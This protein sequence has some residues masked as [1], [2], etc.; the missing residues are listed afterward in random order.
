[1]KSRTIISSEESARRWPVDTTG[2]G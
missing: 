2:S 1:M